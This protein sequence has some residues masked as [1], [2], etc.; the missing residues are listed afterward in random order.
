M[1]FKQYPRMVYHKNYP[2]DPD[3]RDHRRIV[4][5]LEEQMRLGP[6]WF[7]TPSLDNEL[8]A[9]PKNAEVA[10]PRPAPEPVL[11]SEA[12]P[13]TPAE[14][15]QSATPASSEDAELVAFLSGLPPEEHKDKAKARAKK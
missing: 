1:A 10:V 6:G 11:A 3:N 7:D 14:E 4:Q 13:A 8:N 12:A 5:S 9:P 2:S 15:P